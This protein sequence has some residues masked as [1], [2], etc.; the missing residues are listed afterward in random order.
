ML[1]LLYA[2]CLLP[3]YF[4]DNI[5]MVMANDQVFII[6]T[7]QTKPTV[8]SAPTWNNMWNIQ[9]IFVEDIDNSNNVYIM[10]HWN[11][12]SVLP[13]SLVLDLGAAI[14]VNTLELSKFFE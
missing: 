7:K 10:C 11:C 3:N 12:E 8:V 9:G 2:F 6:A 1:F 13:S 5:N 4:F 14:P